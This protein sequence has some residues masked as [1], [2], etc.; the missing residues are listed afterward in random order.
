M[1]AWTSAKPGLPCKSS[2]AAALAGFSGGAEPCGAVLAPVAPAAGGGS[3][4]TGVAS[5]ACGAGTAF[6]AGAAAIFALALATA[7]GVATDLSGC[8]STSIGRLFNGVT[9]SIDL[10]DQMTLKRRGPIQIYYESL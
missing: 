8:A 7:F 10:Q 4:A 3:K 2:V 6:G 9:W 5:N 1:N